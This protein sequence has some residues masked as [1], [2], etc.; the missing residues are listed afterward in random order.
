MKRKDI[1]KLQTDGFIS[2]TLRD[3]IMAHYKLSDKGSRRWMLISLS[4]LAAVL[5]CV[6]VG[7]LVQ[8]HW[9]DMSDM[10]KII[11][12]AGLLL[13]TWVA[14]FAVRT[15]VPLL[16]EGLAVLGA[17]LWAANIALHDSIFHVGAHLVDGC[18]LFLLGIALIP[19]L[20]RNRL[21]IAGVAVTTA[22]LLGAALD[23][24]DSFLHID[25]L[26]GEYGSQYT[27]NV[28]AAYALLGTVWALFS[29]KCRKAQ[30]CF[31]GYYWIS[32]PIILVMICAYQGFI[33]YGGS[34]EFRLSTAGYVMMACIPLSFLF[35]K[36]KGVSWLCWL[37]LAACT[38][39]LVPL[40]VHLS[41]SE[42]FT[43][44]GGGDFL[45]RLVSVMICVAYAIV[46]LVAGARCCRVAWINYGVLLSFF[47]M[48]GVA[49]NIFKSLDG[50]GLSLIISGV[51]VLAF[52]FIADRQRRRLTC[53][54]K[55]QSTSTSAEA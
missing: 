39:A 49:S 42:Y 5:I 30:G 4:L 24:S 18:F 6:G 46:L 35:F 10:F 55:Q 54:I 32:I 53:R 34:I 48:I 22:V 41:W 21:L 29:G 19:F 45:Y 1:E 3:E 52:V 12:G 31:R 15:R 40:A 9:E 43:M 11:A 14:F 28:F 38:G 20:V 27:G 23:Q 37:G 25:W 2:E 50:S 26:D 16:G 33:L 7:L 51:L 44:E 36:Q 8:A 47:A 17:A 13:L